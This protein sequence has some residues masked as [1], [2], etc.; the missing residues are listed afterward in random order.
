MPYEGACRHDTTISGRKET[1]VPSPE[2][3]EVSRYLNWIW[4]AYFADIPRVNLVRIDY[5]YPWK[6]RLG[7]I[8][9]S[10]DQS[11]SFIGINA[12]LQLQQLPEYIL[13]TTIAHEL[14]HYAHGFGSPLPRLWKHPH[15]NKVVDHELE[16]R[17]LGE[18]LCCCNE[19]IDKHWYPFYDMQRE[20]GW[21]KVFGAPRYAPR[22][23]KLG[24]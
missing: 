5:C 15:A 20:L 1:S 16:K 22:I 18:Y 14:T 23:R 13:I 4:G 6:S 9:L 19:W 11:T 2:A 21:E 24:S 8:R 3:R 12:L 7:L 10:E 17:E